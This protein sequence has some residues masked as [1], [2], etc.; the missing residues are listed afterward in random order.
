ML[1]LNLENFCFLKISPGCA[2]NY[3][4]DAVVKIV[5]ILFKVHKGWLGM[6]KSLGLE[7]GSSKKKI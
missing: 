6:K 3:F 7:I 4:V 1:N 5:L 2:V